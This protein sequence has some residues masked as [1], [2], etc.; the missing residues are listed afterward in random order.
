MSSESLG[1]AL[2]ESQSASSS[3]D[4]S[5]DNVSSSVLSSEAE[6]DSSD[7][8]LVEP[9]PKR[10]KG[11]RIHANQ[12]ATSPAPPKV[13]TAPGRQAAHWCYT[14]N[15]PSQDNATLLASLH[16]HNSTILYHFFQ[17]EL[18]ASGTPH[19]QGAI[20]F[21]NRKSM[22]T[23]KRLFKTDT[24]H[25]EPTA[26]T[27]EQACA[28]ASKDDTRVDGPMLRFGTPPA[29]VN[30]QG[31][32]NDLLAVK[33]ELDAGKAVLD[34]ATND[35]NFSTVMKYERSLQAYAHHQTKPR[36]V[37]T[38]CV[39]YYGSPGTYK[40]YS[41]S[42]FANKYHLVRPTSKNGAIWFDGY[43]PNVHTT[44][45]IDDF[46][47]WIPY[48]LLLE[49]LDRYQCHVQRKG[50]VV[51]FRP[52][53]VV[54]TS[55]TAPE[56]WYKFNQTN[57]QYE[58]LMRRIDTIY[59]H[60]IM[61]APFQDLPAGTMTVLADKGLYTQ[62]PLFHSMEPVSGQPFNILKT[63]FKLDEEDDFDPKDYQ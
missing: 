13:A 21:K 15:N 57:M 63:P 18:S 54:I 60:Q 55:N 58:A 7:L 50:G 31:K 37:R 35:E 49:M 5:D 36:T 44:V 32:R 27:P 62:H 47:G 40:S 53:L 20:G 51:E 52:R 1:S 26:G 10:R 38:R 34:I 11:T 56:N 4:S 25:L 3:V 30:G 46:Y 33:S 6:S 16:L 59:H 12:P 17:S 8:V 29:T 39:V 14:L 2:D 22:Q 19:I 61:E 41:A 43:L 23:I 28:Y 42:T 45:V 9:H 24:V 48:S